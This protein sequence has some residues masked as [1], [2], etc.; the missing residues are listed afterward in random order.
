MARVPDAGVAG[1]RL[2]GAAGRV[3]P[4]A[5]AVA[6]LLVAW[7]LVAGHDRYVLPHPLAVADQLTGSPGFYLR[8]AAT[9]LREALGG[10]GIGFVAAWVLALAMTEVRILARALLPLAV[11][12]NVTPVVAVAPAL[13]V[14]FGF[15]VT[16]K[17][18][19]T[20]L[21][22]F[23]PVL[24]NAI[25]GLRSADPLLLDVLEVLHA[26]R[27]EI[28]WRVRL[29]ASLPQ[30]FV[31][32]RI[33]LPLSVIGAVVS[34]FVTQGSTSGLGTVIFQ[35]SQNAELD[36]VYAAVVCLGVVG[37]ALTGIVAVVQ[38]RVLLWQSR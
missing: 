5:V 4:V 15:G 10:L 31:A 37:V 29:P 22:C 28:L 27:R 32:L 8:G 6:I 34:E 11:L 38:R 7:Q 1:R 33:V 16:P 21:I 9:T 2:T 14:A 18:V 35:A 17:L 25:A 26:S 19:V 12:A 13:V 24:V 23:F 30:L 20:A 3:V 36:R